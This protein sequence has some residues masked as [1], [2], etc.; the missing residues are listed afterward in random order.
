M[1]SETTQRRLVA[2]V[3]EYD[4]KLEQIL[5]LRKVKK[6]LRRA[7]KQHEKD[8]A[9]L[10]DYDAVRKQYNANAD[11]LSDVSK[12]HRDAFK[13]VFQLFRDAKAGRLLF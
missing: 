12:G 13:Q 9:P 1:L 2:I 4:R 7:L 11:E 5:N 3:D 6:E 10:P 8:I